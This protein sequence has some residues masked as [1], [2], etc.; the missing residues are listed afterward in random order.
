MYLAQEKAQKNY[1]REFIPDLFKYRG[2]SR[3]T[4]NNTELNKTPELS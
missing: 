3:S 1:R 2:S 4:N